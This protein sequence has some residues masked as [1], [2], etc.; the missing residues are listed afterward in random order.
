MARSTTE[1]GVRG[2]KMHWQHVEWLARELDV[3]GDAGNIIDAL[4]PATVFINI[5]RTDPR[6]QALSFFRARKTAEWCRF[7]GSLRS[8]V[9]LTA[10][11]PN[12]DEITRLERDLHR[13]QE[14]WLRHFTDRHATVLT[15]RYEDLDAEYRTEIARVLQFLGVDSSCAADLPEPHLERQSD[16]ITKAWRVAVDK[17]ELDMAVRK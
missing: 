10:I 14:M 15:V 13:Q 12:Y 4:F 5:V 16:H 17:Y 6:A 2:V 8:E 11:E 1:N 9:D 3:E 7:P